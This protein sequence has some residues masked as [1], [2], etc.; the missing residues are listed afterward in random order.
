VP[1]PEP[2][3]AAPNPI[4][5]RDLPCDDAITGRANETSR[6][7]S[8]APHL[9][10]GV[11]RQAGGAPHHDG[12]P[13]RRREEAARGHDTSLLHGHG[14]GHG[15]LGL[16]DVRSSQHDGGAAGRAAASA[17]ASPA[18]EAARRAVPRAP[19][20]ESSV[21]VSGRPTPAPKDPGTSSPP[22]CRAPKTPARSTRKRTAGVAPDPAPRASRGVPAVWAHPSRDPRA[23][24][25]VPAVWVL[26]GWRPFV[27][28][29]EGTHRW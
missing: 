11:T 3:S 24:R 20:R 8:G 28:P 10:D 4:R 23:S 14:E 7:D 16:T 2:T 27:N 15:D 6:E 19:A 21:P 5:D 9:A 22:R 29:G 25:G 1:E 13:L 17:E 26:R 12:R 18:H